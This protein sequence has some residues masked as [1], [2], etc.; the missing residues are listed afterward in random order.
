MLRG[1]WIQSDPKCLQIFGELGEGWNGYGFMV[2]VHICSLSRFFFVGV[3]CMIYAGSRNIAYHNLNQ[4]N[5]HIN[6]PRFSNYGLS[7]FGRLIKTKA[8]SVDE[9]KCSEGVKY[10]PRPVQWTLN[11][12]QSFWSLAMVNFVCLKQ[13]IPPL[14]LLN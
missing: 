14:T 5:R 10:L 3:Q 12:L 8:F 9:I 1:D 11:S 6:L 13:K 7:T 2:F 4:Y